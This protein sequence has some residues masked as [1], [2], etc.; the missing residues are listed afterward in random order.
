MKDEKQTRNRSIDFVRGISIILII[1]YHVYAI[2]LQFGYGPHIRI[3]VFSEILTF[4]GEIGVT[5][6][7]IMSGYGIYFSL[8][9]EYERT[10]IINI[11]RYIRKRWIRIAPQYYISLAVVL[12]LTEGAVYLS[13]GGIKSV[14]THCLFI[15]NFWPD[16]HGSISGVLWTMGVI[17]Q[18]YLVSVFLYKCMKKAPVVSV[19][20]AIL[21]TIIAKYIIFHVVGTE[22]YFVYGRQLITSLD[23]FMWGMFLAGCDRKQWV[24]QKKRI[25]PLSMF[26]I[27]LGVFS[28]F[29]IYSARR[30]IYADSIIGYM[31]HSV[32]ALLLTGI[33]FWLSRIRICFESKIFYPFMVISKNEYGIYIWHLLIINTV[34]SKSSFVNWLASKSFFAECSF[35]VVVTVIAGFIATKLIDKTLS[36]MISPDKTTE[37][38]EMGSA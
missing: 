8:D 30:T 29:V 20:C 12:F 1:V 28:L 25:L 34:L 37:T 24:I 3:P 31:W 2:S 7:F 33:I 15:H 22:Q 36:Q 27:I 23:N 14:F 21:I 35:F 16:T 4:G 19:L 38:Q 6:F 18:F 26:I 9:K 32:L 11:K 17:V 13:R 10:G 5:L